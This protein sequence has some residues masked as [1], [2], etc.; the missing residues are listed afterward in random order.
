MSKKQTLLE[1]FCE[2]YIINRVNMMHFVH[3]TPPPAHE[4]FKTGSWA[5]KVKGHGVKGTVCDF[6]KVPTKHSR[7]S[8]W[9]LIKR[10][11]SKASLL[12]WI[13]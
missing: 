2:V 4:S 11:A 7:L 12:G 3:L 1:S 6:S 10:W 13:V 8:T 9:M 5:Q